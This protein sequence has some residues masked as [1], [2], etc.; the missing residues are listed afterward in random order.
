MDR[1]GTPFGVAQKKNSS[2]PKNTETFSTAKR[3]ERYHESKFFSSHARGLSV[4]KTK[5]Y[6]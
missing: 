4:Q 6:Q 3:A 1:L 5:L 2:D